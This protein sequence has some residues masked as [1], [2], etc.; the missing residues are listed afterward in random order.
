[1]TLPISPRW[2]AGRLVFSVIRSDDGIGQNGRIEPG[3]IEHVIAFEMIQSS[4]ERMILSPCCQRLASDEGFI[5]ADLSSTDEVGLS[6]VVGLQPVAM[7]ISNLF[8]FM[9]PP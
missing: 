6:V 1:M 7:G 5:G 2:V 9:K 4:A 3:H 8:V